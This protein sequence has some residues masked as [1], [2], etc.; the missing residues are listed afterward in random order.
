MPCEAHHDDLYGMRRRRRFR[1]GSANLNKN[2]GPRRYSSDTA[3]MSRR[4]D[5]IC[6]Q[7]VRDP[8]DERALRGGLGGLWRLAHAHLPIPIAWR[9]LK[10]KLVDSGW[11]KLHSGNADIPNPS[12]YVC[13]VVLKPRWLPWARPF[14]VVNTHWVNGAW[15]GKEAGNR[16]DEKWRQEKW[17]IDWQGCSDLVAEHLRAG[18]TTFLSGDLNKL[19]V[20]PLVPGWG[21]HW[22]RGICKTGGVQGWQP[23]KAVAGE[24]VPLNSDHDG[25]VLTLELRRP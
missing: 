20:D 9:R 16:W 24:R 13:W 5:V 19:K 22:N 21:W 4:S 14:C 25:H 10:F 1:L 6:F 12:R 17:W 3:E 11:R 18:R 7:E 2:M 8:G 15:N 23:Y